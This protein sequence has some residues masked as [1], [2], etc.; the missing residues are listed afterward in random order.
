VDNGTVSVAPVGIDAIIRTPNDVSATSSEGTLDV[1]VDDSSDTVQ[2]N[3]PDGGC[4]VSDAAGTST[5]ELQANNSLTVIGGDVANAVLANIPGEIVFTSYQ[6]GAPEIYLMDTHGENLTRLTSN[7][8][9]D[10]DPN[11]SPSGTRIV[12]Q[13]FNTVASN[14]DI[15]TIN[16]SGGEPTILT[17]QGSANDTE[18]TWS[19][20][21]SRIAFV[22]DRDGN[23]EI[24]VMNRDGSD[25]QRL[26]NDALQDTSPTWSPDGT[27]LAF[28]SRRTGNDEIYILTLGSDELP[29]NLTQNQSNDNNPAWSPDGTKIAFDSTRDSSIREVYVMNVDGSDVINLSNHTARDEE[30]SWSPDSQQVVFVSQRSGNNKIFI[31]QIDQSSEPTN[32]SGSVSYE[33]SEPSWLPQF[34]ARAS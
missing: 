9:Q 11:W 3:C 18:P 15:A 8:T 31:V 33:Q 24:Y 16:P 5:V 12:Y 4:S 20:D 26:T 23:Q 34:R 27:Q 21:G 17:I 19:P 29:V 22:S 32:L 2:V 25:V 1:Q 14:W 13:T 28:V 6:H 30:P 7:V 10:L